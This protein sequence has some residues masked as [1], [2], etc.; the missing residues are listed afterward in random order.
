MGEEL[1]PTK[2]LHL[3]LE[4]INSVFIRQGL[5]Q[6]ERLVQLNKIA[7]TQMTSLMNSTQLKKLK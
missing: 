4:S 2:I 5:T 6:S 1:L 7:I 3:N